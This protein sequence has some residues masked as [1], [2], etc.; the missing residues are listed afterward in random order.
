MG[1]RLTE[2]QRAVLAELQWLCDDAPRWA[3]DA[4]EGWLPYHVRFFRGGD[5]L[6]AGLTLPAVRQH[7]RQ[8]RKR[9]LAERIA[10]QGTVSYRITD[11]GRERLLADVDQSE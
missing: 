6:A 2:K 11:A 3:A 8:L 7:L 1:T 9:G 4:M 10:E 5:S